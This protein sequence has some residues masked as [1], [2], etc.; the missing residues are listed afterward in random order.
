MKH[1]RVGYGCDI[2]QEYVDIAWTRVNALEDGTLRTRPMSKPV[3]D[4]QKPY[5]GHKPLRVHVEDATPTI[6]ISAR[7]RE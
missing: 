4:P 5:G 3:Y 6:P 1:D 2:I 7:P